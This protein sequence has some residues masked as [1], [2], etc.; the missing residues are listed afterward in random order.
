MVA[1]LLLSY[2]VYLLL[3]GVNGNASCLFATVEGEQQ[4]LYWMLVIFILMA[5][6][7]VDSQLAKPFVV[8]VV[9][10]F[11]LKDS[12]WKT[13]ANNAKQVLPGL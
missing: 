7:D 1:V 11:L 6:W 13:I 9:L 4:F 12:N 8:L 5:L 3:V 10:G 2:A